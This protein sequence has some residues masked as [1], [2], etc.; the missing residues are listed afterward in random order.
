[1]TSKKKGGGTGTPAPRRHDPFYR[2]ID[3]Y[4]RQAAEAGIDDTIEI[5]WSPARQPD[6]APPPSEPFAAEGDGWPVRRLPRKGLVPAPGHAARHLSSAGTGAMFVALFDVPPERVALAVR[7]IERRY[8]EAGGPRPIFLTD[9]PDTRAIRHAGFTHEYFPRQIYGAPEQAA[10]FEARFVTLWKKW[11]GKVL[12]DLGAQGYLAQRIDELGKY[13][14]RNL[15]GGGL[16]DPRLPRPAPRPAP[17]TDVVALKA[18]YRLS[19]LHEEPDTFVLYRI[20]GND[21]PPR[22]EAGQTLANLRF[23]LDHEPE[24]PHC[25]KR[26]VVNRIVDPEQEAAV[27]AL[28]EERGQSWLH[29]PFVLEE[30]GKAGWDLESFFDGEP[31]F[32][33]GKADRMTPYDRARAEAHLRRHKNNYL[34][35]NNGARN[36]A[37]RDGKTRAKWVLPWDGNCFLTAAAWNEI[38]AGV[39]AEPYLKYFTVPMSRTL[40][41]ADLLDPTHRPEADGEPQIVFRRDSA[42]EFDENR[43]YGRR[44]KVEMFYR[45]G[46]PGGWDGYMDDVWD[47][48]RPELSKDAGAC[49]AAGWVA[50]LFS[51]QKELEGERGTDLRSRG[52]ARIA[53]VTKMLDRFDVA[54]MEL[55]YRPERLVFYDET[56]VAALRD[57][58]HGSADATLSERLRIE[59]DLALQRGPYSVTQK[60]SRPPSGDP[61]DYYH[62]APYY[63]PNPHTPDGLPYLRRDGERV[64]GTRLYEPESERYDRTRLQGLFD[65]TTLLA[66]GWLA[67]DN[68]AYIA[69]AAG[70]IRTWFLDEATRMTPH[71]LYAQTMSQTAADTG[72]AFGLIELK[73]LYFFLDAVRLVERAGA[74]TEAEMT[75]FRDWLREYLEWLETSPQGMKERLSRN[76]HGACYDLQ[77]GAIAAFLGDAERLERIFLTSRER[78]LEQFADDGTQPEEMTRTQTAHYC[79]FNLQSW[80]N[81]ATLAE[82]CGHDLWSFEGAKGRGLARAFEWLLPHMEQAAWPHPQI[83]PFDAERFLPLHLAARERLSTMGLRRLVDPAAL[84]PIYFAHDGIRPFWMLGRSPR[85]QP[86]SACWTR[87]AREAA[88]FERMAHDL[89]ERQAAE[90]NDDAEVLERKLGQG[91]VET[92][93]HRLAQIEQDEAE[94]PHRRATAARALALWQYGERNHAA[95]R[96]HAQVW[97]DQAEASG[98]PAE[99]TEHQ[100]ALLDAFCADALGLRDDAVAQLRARRDGASDITELD[101]ALAHC[102]R[103]APDAQVA[104]INGIYAELC[105]PAFLAPPGDGATWATQASVAAEPA[106]EEPVVTVIVTQD[107]DVGDA[108]AALASIRAQTWVALDVI[109][110]DRSGDAAV[111]ERLAGIA[112]TDPRVGILSLPADIDEAAALA[113]ALAR[114]VGRYVTV[115]AASD[116][117][118]PMRIALQLE[119]LIDG[120]ARASLCDGFRVAPDRGIVPIRDGGFAL[121]GPDAQSLLVDRDALDVAG[122]A[123]RAGQGEED[124]A[125]H[126]SLRDLLERAGHIPGRVLPGLP[127]SLGVLPAEARAPEAADGRFD[128]VFIADFSAGG[129]ALEAILARVAAEAGEGRSVG[130][131]H[132][133]DYAAA[134]A[135]AL[136]AAVAGMLSE[137]A[138][139]LIR[140]HD[141]A[142]ASRVVLC[143]PFVIRH[144]LAGLPDFGQDRLEVFGGPE[145]HAGEYRAPRPRHLPAPAEVAV[146]FGSQPVWTSL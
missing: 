8:L 44:P 89:V 143:N 47:I 119:P 58:A 43:S 59:A 142:R 45:L 116:R 101:L 103:N 113:T 100:V 50:R 138:V 77:T 4:E 131:F 79:C 105:L 14:G 46:I 94:A 20:L 13:F 70:L 99:A 65:D 49:G 73:D 28:L 128:T 145:L 146:V 88:E 54:A 140:P 127:L 27:I 130:L 55:T 2:I 42:E 110:I 87:L 1:M 123:D 38:A 51:G 37:L 108:D 106:P 16:F 25:E 104:R 137:G 102:E 35:N 15:H 120:T 84:R 26:F 71:L 57:A 124:N 6:P 107:S 133:P 111:R 132:W 81:L 91:F 141:P 117:A 121:V 53:A 12:V 136:D 98:T 61:Q 90:F 86:Q 31:F 30:Y 52:E 60:T 22:H 109:V 17:V 80:V 67:T 69:H 134:D 75:A 41:N 83:D 24:F 19:G 34:V 66:L 96:S 62:P 72:S 11:N 112:A 118:H 23:I 7:L 122:G 144:P 68:S 39:T 5:A 36:A 21:L 129:L 33:R 10:L 9:S 114:A 64:P 3:I 125:P 95:A 85:V 78:I 56:A 97:R 82:A 92:A 40:D 32:L 139:Q 93:G 18:D 135:G 74:L 48:P 29:I 63:W 115:M 76:N 126:A